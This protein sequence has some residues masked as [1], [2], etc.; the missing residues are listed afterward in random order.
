MFAFVVF[1]SVI[2]YYI[3]SQEIGWEK[4]SEMTYLCRVRRRTLTQSI[5]HTLCL[6][7]SVLMPTALIPLGLLPAGSICFIFLLT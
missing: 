7:C 3:L 2:Q 1:A 6:W 5:C 4:G